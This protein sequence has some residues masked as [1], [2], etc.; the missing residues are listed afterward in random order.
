MSVDLF[1]VVTLRYDVILRCYCIYFGSNYDLILNMTIEVLQP[2]HNS[3]HYIIFSFS[4]I[5]VVLGVIDNLPFQL[6]QFEDMLHLKSFSCYNINY[7]HL[8]G[9]RFFVFFFLLKGNINNIE[10]KSEI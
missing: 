10:G 1:Y 2:K 4:V 9:F 3:D 7:S 5:F 6:F 8:K